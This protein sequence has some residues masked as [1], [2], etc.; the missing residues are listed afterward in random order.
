MFALSSHK[1]AHEALRLGL[2]RSGPQYNVYVIGP[3]QAGRMTATLR[4]V[5]R[6]AAEH[7][8]A[9]DWVY[10]VD[11]DAPNRPRPLALPAGVG[12]EVTSALDM[13]LPHLA[14]E[15]A[16]AFGSEAYQQQ[17][18]QLRTGAQA[19]VQDRSQVAEQRAREL[20]LV[21]LQGPEGPVIAA[22]NDKGEPVQVQA[23]PA[24]Q[25][26]R[27]QEGVTEL[28]QTL[29]EINRVAVRAQQ[30]LLESVQ[31]LATDVSKRATSGL[32]QALA[33]RYKEIEALHVWFAG[34]ESDVVA[35]YQMFLKPEQPVPTPDATRALRRYGINLLVDRRLESR[36][37]VVLEQNPTYEN[38]FGKI[39]YRQ[40]PG[41]GLE[42]DVSLIQAGSLHHA[43]GGV[44]VLRAADI[45]SQPGVWNYLKAALRD[46][47][48]RIEEFYRAGAPPIAGAPQAR[49][50]P[51][52]L[53]V[54]M[55]GAP[56]LYHLVFAAD[57]EFSSY[58]KIKAQI[59]SLVDATPDDLG[60]YAGLLSEYARDRGAAIDHGALQLLLGIAARW[61]GHR[62][63]VVTSYEAVSN[64]IEEA[65]NGC[66]VVDRS[67]ILDAIIA[68]RRRNSYVEDEVHRGI[69]D[70]QTI[71]AVRGEAV[72]QVNGL[73][74]QS[75]GDHTFGTPA[76]ITARGSVGRRGVVNIERQVSMSGPIQQK[77]SLTLQGLLA[78]KFSRHA[79]LAFDCSVT[80]EQLYG[81]VEGDSAS[82][83]EYV[84]IISDLADLPIRQDLAITGSVNQLGEAQVIGGVHHKIEGFFRVC[85]E[86]GELTGQQGVVIPKG[87]TRNLVLRDGVTKAI[88][89][90]RF[91]IYS[92]D[93]ADD[94]VAIFTG[95][96]VGEPGRG[97][98]NS[99]YGR[100]VKALMTF[101]RV[102]AERGL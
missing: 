88:A 91:H 10:L 50:I 35:N 67:I 51:L 68:R 11:F 8:P 58:F 83:A 77:A 23:M 64:L 48:I 29:A 63:R 71:I 94:A 7:P 17:V 85:S 15:I 36:R 34:L 22:L 52:D 62:E 41:G 97:G 31:Q 60:V 69:L 89:E 102:L 98:D 82:L 56:M 59:E 26:T 40:L 3:D 78:R 90:G 65:C 100:V 27:L 18:V 54:V 47:E 74:V 70:G 46:R 30:Q 72:G 101:D 66:E 16:T 81:G 20:G 75:T 5:E 99:V 14:Q 84:A 19:E 80:F 45:A 55:I 79:P 49:G 12:A 92:I 76:R 2:E 25:Q 39:E 9:D 93:S 42:T 86:I 53:T 33:E 44:L 96:E 38:L 13:L 43:N 73:T 61:A 21:V 57:P 6:W 95:L 37:P 28:A 32:I 24:D 4:Y 87:N 1:R